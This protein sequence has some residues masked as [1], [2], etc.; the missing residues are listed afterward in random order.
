MS[1]QKKTDRLRQ[2]YN[3]QLAALARFEEKHGSANRA[4]AKMGWETINTFGKYVVAEGEEI[5][6][7]AEKCLAEALAYESK[8]NNAAG[9]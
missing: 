5:A 3:N 1:K 2:R 9:H 6:D 7:Y 8:M 4:V